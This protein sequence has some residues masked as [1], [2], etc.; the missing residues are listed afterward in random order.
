MIISIDTEKH[1]TKFN[2]N[3]WQKLSSKLELKDISQNTE[4]HLWQNPQLTTRWSSNSTAGNILKNWLIQNIYSKDTCTPMFKGALF[5]IA[6]IW[7]QCRYTSINRQIDEEDMV[8]VWVYTHWILVIKK[9]NSSISNNVDEPRRYY[10]KWNVR[11]RQI[12]YFM[13]SLFCGI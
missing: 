5:V 10:A 8:C 11:Q 6:R 1:L 2:I 13:L 3:P 4:G 9:W 7:K 12:K